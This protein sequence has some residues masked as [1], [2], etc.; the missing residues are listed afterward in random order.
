MAYD[1]YALCPCGSGK[2]L[3]FCCQNIADDMERINRLIEDNQFRAAL[4]QL[5]TL[6]KRQPDS[7][8][9]TTTRALI[10]I[11]TGEAITA[12]DLLRPWLQAH[13]EGEFATV[14]FALAQMQAEGYDAAKKSI[15]RAYQKGAKKFPGLVSGL[16]GT[17]ALAM[18]E[19]GQA[20]AARECLSLALRFA[21]ER[22]R[23]D[24]F[25]RLV[26]F[27]NDAEFFYPLRSMH[28]LPATEVPAELDKDY[29]RAMKLSAIGCWDMAADLLSSLAEKLPDRPG[30]IQASG[31]CRAWDGDSKRAAVDLHTAAAK[32]SDRAAAVECEVLAQLF[33]LIDA[34]DL[35]AL[36]SQDGTIPSVSRL[37]TTLD[38]QPQMVRLPLP[39]DAVPEG[40]LTPAAVYNVLDRPVL[41]KADALALSLKTVPRVRANII[42]YDAHDDEP[43]RLTLS[44]LAGGEFEAALEHAKSVAGDQVVWSSDTPETVQEFPREMQIFAWQWSLPPQTPMGKRHELER[45]QW[46]VVI[47][48][49]WPNQAQ[50]ALGGLSPLDAAKQPEMSTRLTAAVYV[51]DAVCEQRR[52]S[53]DVPALLGRLGLEP[54]PTLTLSADTAPNTLSL[55]QLHRVNISALTDPQLLSVVNRALLIHHDAFLQ[56]VLE[57]ALQRTSCLEQL[58]L[59]RIYQ[60]LVDICFQHGQLDAALHWIGEAKEKL[61]G[62]QPTFEQIWTWELRELMLRLT[63]PDDPKLPALLQKFAVFY[64]P[65]IP[66]LRG[67]LEAILKEAGVE[68]PWT[69]GAGLI[70]ND[71]A[72]GNTEGSLWTPGREPATAAAGK[73][74]L[75]GQ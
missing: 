52:H 58:D 10:L 54:L 68:S 70:T 35:C 32:L 20:L 17:V 38:D 34:T 12:R 19:R 56:P 18:Q 74:W 62:P 73:L 60:T 15:Q 21:S 27:D 25:V 30:L 6:D 7:E 1:P 16:A 57:T 14:L 36:L 64:G 31:L 61:L 39:P 46:Q 28:P 72:S 71:L 42:I 47:N 33:D 55:L 29:K 65:K 48:E 13:P 8:W 66:Q 4:K 37:L 44:G 63:N 23:Q 45:Q 69:T 51:L 11:E 3:K 53:L 9:I 59:A 5:E 2:K 50:I 75:P 41:T 24:I 40:Q 49:A 22:D 43:A 67:Y 26:E